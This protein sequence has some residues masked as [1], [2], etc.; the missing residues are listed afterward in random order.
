M[1]ALR[2]LFVD[3]YD[4]LKVRLIRRLGSADRAGDAL[5]DTW[6]RLDRLETVG[7]VQSPRN[8]LFRIA[9][10]VAYQQRR[11]ETRH[12]SAT[13]VEGLLDIPD[14]APSPEEI[15]LARSDLDAFRSILA[16]L[17][18]RRRAIFLAARIGN[19]PRQTIA[20]RLGISRRLVA[21][22]LFLAHKHFVARYRELR[23]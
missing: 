10:N 6:L 15:V 14:D 2:R 9:L 7:A 23:D 17:P 13:E 12:V 11:L 4:D 18:A 20:D 3:G 8:Y 19:V 21:K 1:A 16:E 5:H 22:E